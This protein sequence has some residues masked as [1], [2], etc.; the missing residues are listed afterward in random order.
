MLLPVTL[1]RNII[2]LRQELDDFIVCF[3]IYGYI[4]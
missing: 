1:I 2:I 4:T 3:D